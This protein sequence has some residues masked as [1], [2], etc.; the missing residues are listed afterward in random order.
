MNYAYVVEVIKSTII[1]RKPIVAIAK[2]PKYLLRLYY[3]LYIVIKL[4]PRA[5]TELVY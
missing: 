4:S 1:N 2:T 5:I 3:Y